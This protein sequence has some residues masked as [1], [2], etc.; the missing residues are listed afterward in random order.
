MKTGHWKIV[1]D[2]NFVS[3]KKIF[4]SK[5]ALISSKMLKSNLLP[6]RHLHLLLALPLPHLLRRTKKTTR[7]NQTRNNPNQNNH[8]HNNKNNH[9]HNFINW[10][11]RYLYLLMLFV[12]LF[13][14]LSCDTF[15][16][17][18]VCLCVFVVMTHSFVYFCLFC[19]CYVHY[20]YSLY[21]YSTHSFVFKNNQ[22]TKFHNLKHIFMCL[23]IFARMPHT[24][25]LLHP[26]QNKKFPDQIRR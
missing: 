9:R 11:N 25:V 12:V 10:H 13:F 2:K 21:K 26:H 6:D 17:V 4:E 19:S 16:C 22:K 3:A 18:L 8:N 1:W 20:H 5:I 24:C 15:V 14:L 7:N 23:I